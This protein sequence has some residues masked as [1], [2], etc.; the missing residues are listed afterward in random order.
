M[1]THSD[2]AQTR[3]LVMSAAE[4]HAALHPDVCKDL[5]REALV[6]LAS[7]DVFLPQ[8]TVVRPP[9]SPGLI[10][11]MPA[12]LS[13]TRPALGMKSV[14]VFHD[15]PK[16]GKDA[17]QGVVTLFD[18]QTG[19]PRAVI[20]AA[21]ITEIRTAAVSALATEVLARPDASVMTV[22]GAGTQ[23]R[24]HIR[25]L[26][27]VRPLSE[28]RII[29][30]SLDKAQRLVEAEAS[31]ISITAHQDPVAA[32]KGADIIVTATTSQDPVLY[33]D[34]VDPGTHINAVGSSVPTAAEIEPALI[35]ASTL[36]CD[37]REALIKESGDF[38]RAQAANVVTERDIS[39]ELG[40]VLVGLA[41]GR[42]SA[43]EITL[44]KSL[45][46]AIEDVIV[47]RYLYEEAIANNLGQWT[48]F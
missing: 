7:G 13:T 21:A 23:A 26:S 33:R 27:R 10:A 47:A 29:S 35:A 17:H 46:L 14:C 25:A 32:T 20:N 18:D 1:T 41:K 38:L 8:R 37:R 48:T 16:K 3:L 15:N 6:T 45:G 24:A 19:E 12:H 22:F 40:E 2:T 4:V 11:L 9:Q 42:T 5:M 31:H 43:S 34:H 28:I 36:I 39:G 44:F 30:R